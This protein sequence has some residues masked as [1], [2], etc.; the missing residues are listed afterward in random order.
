MKY[1]AIYTAD[2]ETTVNED[3]SEVWLAGL[4]NIYTE[5]FIW[6]DNQADFWTHIQT[7]NKPLIYFHNLKFDGQFILWHWLHNLSMTWTPDRKPGKNQFSTIISDMNQYYKFTAIWQNGN[8]AEIRDSLKIIRMPVEAIPQAF[9][10]DVGKGSIAYETYTEKPSHINPEEVDYLKRDCLIPARAIRQLW[11]AG[12]N[13]L[14]SASNAMAE[15][16]NFIGQARFR[17]LFPKLSYE[18]DSFIRKAYKGG[19]VYVE[20]AHQGEWCGRGFV[21]DVNSLYPSRCASVENT[22]LPF[23]YPEY[24][25]GKPEKDMLYIVQI[26]ACF[27]LKEGYLPTI[28]IKN[29]PRFQETEYLKSS[30]VDGQPTAIELYLT[31]VDLEIFLRHYDIIGGLEYIQGF[32]FQSSP[33]LWRGYVEKNMKIK[34]EA[35]KAGNKGLRTIAKNNMNEPTGKFAT[36]PEQYSATPFLDEIIKTKTYNEYNPNGDD[37]TPEKLEE[38]H[39]EMEKNIIYTAMSVFITAYGRQ[40]MI[41]TAQRLHEQGIFRYCDT[42][43]AHCEGRMPLWLWKECDHT[44]LGKW[45]VENTFRK[46]KFLRAKTYMEFNKKQV[47][48]KPGL[49]T[50]E[51]DVKCAGLPHKLHKQVTPENFKIGAIYEGKLLKKNVPG[52]CILKETT[53]EIK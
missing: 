52:G 32:Y 48:G 41:N 44:A 39:K 15:Y 45:D 29:S 28:Q 34:E 4:M 40:K 12:H 42:D 46:A 25:T 33:D 16:K 3:F 23:G 21:V 13:K 36:R 47:K 24:F 10:L 1:S 11:D 53:F 37:L 49:I 22:P 17:T 2:F 9:G 51:W 35:T 6:F 31:N 14:S 27:I 5:E 38:I 8:R 20:E 26:R 7:L 43:S 19:Y 30:I 18:T 50:Y